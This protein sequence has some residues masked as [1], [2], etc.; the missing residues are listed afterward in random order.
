[1]VFGHFLLDNLE[2]LGSL[3]FLGLLVFLVNL[4]LLEV[5]GFLGLLVFLAN[6]GLPGLL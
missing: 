6:L 2:V 4:G 3:D 5:L 1:M